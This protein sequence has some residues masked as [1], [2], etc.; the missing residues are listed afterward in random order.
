MHG[1]KGL[2][3][4]TVVMPGLE[5]AHLPGNARTEEIPERQRLYYVALTRATDHVLITVPK[6]R[7]RGDP[8]NFPAPGRGE[9]SPFVAQSG[10]RPT[11]RDVP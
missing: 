11:Y 10:I 3:R 7:A 6:T 1:S 9:P 4:H 8:F 5:G 2:T